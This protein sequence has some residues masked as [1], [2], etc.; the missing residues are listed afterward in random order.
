M[1]RRQYLKWSSRPIFKI[2]KQFRN[3]VVATVKEK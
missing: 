2:E 1:T 3:G